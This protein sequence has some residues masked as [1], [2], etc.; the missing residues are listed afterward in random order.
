VA[1][2]PEI[3]WYPFF[4]TGASYW[5]YVASSFT[6]IWIPWLDSAVSV[7]C[8][9]DYGNMDDVDVGILTCLSSH[10]VQRAF[11]IYVWYMNIWCTE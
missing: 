6:L 5:F 4:V 10:K 2:V 1:K 8:I 7:S 11:M 9:S 3:L